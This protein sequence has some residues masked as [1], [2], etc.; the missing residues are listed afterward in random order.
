MKSHFRIGRKL[1]W[2]FCAF[3]A[4]KTNIIYQINAEKHKSAQKMKTN[5]EILLQNFKMV[6]KNYFSNGIV[7]L[8]ERNSVSK[9]VKKCGFFEMRN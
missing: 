6:L 7:H 9:K 5:F 3:R 8:Q 4:G 1:K 2:D